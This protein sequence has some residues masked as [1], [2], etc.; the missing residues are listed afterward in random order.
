M[1]AVHVSVTSQVRQAWNGVVELGRSSSLRRLGVVAAALA[2]LLA[3]GGRCAAASE[4][5]KDPG[6]REHR[7][8]TVSPQIGERLIKANDLLDDGKLDDALDL[9]DDTSKSRRL[10]PPDVAQLHRFRGY[11][12]V[13]KGMSEEAAAEFE[14]SLA[15]DALDA[16]AEQAMTYSLAQI[17]TQLDR[18]D[19]ALELIEA[20]F[21][22]TDEPK[23]DAYFLKA[24][25]LVQQENFDAALEPA[26]TAVATSPQP[27][28]S[29]L[30]LLAAIH[31]QRQDFP[32]LATV[33]ER[34][35][36]MAPATKRYWVQLATIQNHLGADAQALATLRAAHQAGL[37]TEDQELR[38][39]ARLLFMR[40]LP[41]EC[42]TVL[43][44]GLAAGTVK[45]DAESYRLTA[46]CFI[47]ARDDDRAIGPLAK[48]GELAADGEMYMLLG[49]LHLQRD[50][51]EPARDV[52]GKAL[53]KAKPEQR[54][55]AHLLLGVAQLGSDRFEDAERAFRA[56]QSDDK[57]RGAAESYLKFLESQRARRAEK[58]EPRNAANG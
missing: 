17:Y 24:S 25:I 52:L 18:Y 21:A 6:A 37:L 7:N 19:R 31:F 34:L 53:A 29:W 33:L 39:L 58:T 9:I 10:E 54:G 5:K 40:E 32:A 27:R 47:A 26:T 14:K 8:V 30:Q 56:A 50:Q 49:Q 16:S 43:E 48:A 13:S 3:I 44:A 55:P 2:A 28:E 42:A 1:L 11:I 23:A 4:P 51:F 12:L 15:Q 22:G 35:V 57:V 45:A 46:N 36:E 41:F 20:W 38:Q